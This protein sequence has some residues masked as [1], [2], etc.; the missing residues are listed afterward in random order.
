MYGINWI[1]IYVWYDVVSMKKKDITKI[2]LKCV[3]V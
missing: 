2:C 3:F 1:N